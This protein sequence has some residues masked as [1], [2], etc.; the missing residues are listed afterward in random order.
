MCTSSEG[1]EPV[2]KSQGVLLVC[3]QG[4]LLGQHNVTGNETTFWDEAPTC[5]F[6][7]LVVQ[8]P[9]V[10]CRSVTNSVAL[11]AIATPDVEEIAGFELRQLYRGEPLPQ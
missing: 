8:F 1:G 4:N 11:A 9:N 5:D 7:P 10:C 2:R 6:P 3:L